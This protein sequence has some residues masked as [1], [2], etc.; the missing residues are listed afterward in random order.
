MPV[1]VRSLPAVRRAGR[2]AALATLGLGLVCCSAPP[3]AD[4]A[5][6]ATPAPSAT[7][8]ATAAPSPAAMKWTGTV[9][10][11][12]DPVAKTLAA[13]PQPNVNDLA[14]TRQSYLTYLGTA[15]QQA[16]TARQ[17]IQA[18]GKPPVDNGDQISTQVSEQAT[19]LETDLTQARDQVQKT[20]PNDPASVTQALTAAGNV[21]GSLTNSA[22]LL[23]AIRKNSQLSQAFDQAPSCAPL[24]KASG[25]S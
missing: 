17:E 3:A 14:A 25:G 15:A 22:Q 18:A 9:C 4:T 20:N 10:S 24:R 2:A 19:Q 5:P 1:Q 7:A 8:G 6:T 11:A 16:G 21:G 12:L 23:S 13:P